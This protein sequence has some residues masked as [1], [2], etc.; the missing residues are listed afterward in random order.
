MDKRDNSKWIEI[1]SW[2]HGLQAYIWAVYNWRIS[3]VFNAAY[4]GSWEDRPE[5][6]REEKESKFIS[7][8]LGWFSSL[9][10]EHRDR[11]MTAIHDKYRD[12]LVQREEMGL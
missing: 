3:D 2:G 8:K 10:S 6:Y 12:H 9:D 4:D 1:R 11:L 5:G 7:D